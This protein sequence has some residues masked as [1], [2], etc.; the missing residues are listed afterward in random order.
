[1]DQTT[2]SC[3]ACNKRV[4]VPLLNGDNDARCPECDASLKELS[5]NGALA[6][7]VLKADGSTWGGGTVDFEVRKDPTE[8]SDAS[9]PAP[10]DALLIPGFEILAELGRGGMGV[11]Y[12]ARQQSLNRIVAIKMIRAGLTA[13]EEERRRFQAEAEAVAQLQHANIVQV[14]EVGEAHGQPYFVL[15]FVEGT[16]LDHHIDEAVLAPESAALLVAQLSEAMEAAHRKGIVHRDL[17]P[18]NVL[19]EVE[20]QEPG[21]ESNHNK[22]SALN[23]QPAALSPKITDFGLA[24]Q[25]ND[26]G[27]TQT[28]QIL[29]TPNYMA[30]EQAA[31]ESRDVGASADVYALG[32][33]LYASLTG[34]PPF[35]G[36]TVIE[37]LDF[38]RN[39][40]PVAPSQLRPGVPRDLETICLKCLRKEPSKRYASA[41]ALAD[42]LNRFLNGEAILGRPVGYMERSVKWAKRRKALAGFLLTSFIA[43]AVFVPTML[44]L[45]LRL[46]SRNQDLSNTNKK[47][48]AAKSKAELEK[49]K[50]NKARDEEKIA[51]IAAQNQNYALTIRQI[52]ELYQRVYPNMERA[53]DLLV[54]L[55]PSSGEPDNRSY[56]WYFLERILNVEEE[57][58][59]GYAAGYDSRGR[60]ILGTPYA[61]VWKKD[62]KNVREVSVE[63]EHSFYGASVGPNGNR[64]ASIR[65]VKKKGKHV[66]HAVW[67]NANNPNRVFKLDQFEQGI[68]SKFAW[69]PDGSHLALVIHNGDN[70]R[71]LNPVVRVWKLPE[72]K[73]IVNLALKAA[74]QVSGLAI[75]AG[76]Q[77]LAVG[78]RKGTTS[79]YRISDSKLQ[80]SI[81][82]SDRKGLG[83]VAFSPNGDHLC[84]AGASG[85]IEIWD[86]A[87]R[88]RVT[89]RHVRRLMPM[90]AAYSP[91]GNS[92]AIGSRNS[93]VKVIDLK[94]R[95]VRSYR[96][97]RHW[98]SNVRFSPDGRKLVSSSFRETRVWNANEQPTYDL[99]DRLK[100]S[101]SCVA[102]SPDGRLMIYGGG[103]DFSQEHRGLVVRET[104][105]RKIRFEIPNLSM[106]SCSFSPNGRWLIVAS[107]H[108]NDPEEWGL[109]RAAAS[110]VDMKSAKVVRKI[111]VPHARIF[112]AHFLSNDRLLLGC[113]DGT[114]RIWNRKTGQE[115]F[116]KKIATSAIMSIAHAPGGDSVFVR[117][118]AP[119]VVGMSLKTGGIIYRHE[120]N[121]ST[122]N[123]AVSP[124]GRLLA[125]PSP[126]PLFNR[127]TAPPLMRRLAAGEGIKEH[128]NHVTII[129][130]PTGKPIAQ[131]AGHSGLIRRVAFSADGKRLVTTS[132]DTTIK[133]WD[134]GTRHELITLQIGLPVSAIAISPDNREL[135]CAPL[136]GAVMRFGRSRDSK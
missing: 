94:T 97:H 68:L 91:D 81:R 58:Y 27:Q 130:L 55:V 30:P 133:V 92:V 15:E 52:Y 54:G 34:R 11:V 115:T 19:L 118:L 13:G 99:I 129:H 75:S 20:S 88:K 28:G 8:P 32:A 116:K 33:I 64:I 134:I 17:K 7:T 51:K 67:R 82:T 77:L 65:S 101:I 100:D 40:E 48:R 106:R 113:D 96:G 45:A 93:V 56:E 117:C 69:S 78:R 5:T 43:V 18:G 16:S 71:R 38:V 37:T 121:P 26:R 73:R 109:Q 35:V 76:N 70:L 98:I 10:P 24:K 87:S 104:I 2:I 114:L 89:A 95:F 31:G 53:R 79:L 39:N 124:D 49:N 108:I 120:G 41:Q 80:S 126:N 3:P 22:P 14:Y 107:A 29:G 135:L 62:G 111:E 66:Y 103:G 46:S 6:K 47:L 9:T 105:S 102:Y 59:S 23:R 119:E 136:N 63:F 12:K 125:V 127:K 84:T 131:L 122:Q 25:T 36:E 60:L 112:Q 44:I 83:A 128:E 85:G 132:D 110:L 1:M 57:T 90:C 74:D 86:V 42:D 61:L 50:A 21:A 4:G 72:G 123:V